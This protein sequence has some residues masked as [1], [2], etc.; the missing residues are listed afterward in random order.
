MSKGKEI[1]EQATGMSEDDRA[2]VLKEIYPRIQDEVTKACLERWLMPRGLIMVLVG[3]DRDDEWFGDFAIGTNGKSHHQ[4]IHALTALS[5]RAAKVIENRID[6][7]VN[8][9]IDE[10]GNEEEE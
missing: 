7:H 9:L 1:F 4:R 2:S 3:M 5:S 10:A 8:K 6:F